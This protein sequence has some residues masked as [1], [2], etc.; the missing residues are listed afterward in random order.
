MTDQQHTVG[1]DL[2]KNS[3]YIVVVDKSCRVVEKKKRTRSQLVSYIAQR[4]ESTIAMEACASSHYWARTL[5]QLGHNVVLLPAQH[6]KGYSRGQKND[7]ND[8]Q[9]IAEAC[10]HGAIRPVLPKTVDEQDDST[11]ARIRQQLVHDRTRLA[12]HIRGILAE[13]GI[14]LPVGLHILKRSLPEILEDADNQLTY[15]MR[16]LLSRQRE[17]LMALDEEVDWYDEQLKQSVEKDS[18]CQR[19]LAIPGV[20]DIVAHALKQ[21][22]GNGQQFS[23]G[24]DASA[25]LGLV[26]RQHSTGGKARLM[27]ISKRGDARVRSA[28][29]HGARAVVS[30]ASKKDD[31][32]SRWI[33][34][35]VEHRGFNRAVVAYANKMVR[36]AW[37]CVAKK[38]RFLIR[39]AAAA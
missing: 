27:G 33:Q 2:A 34:R 25:A 10:H 28:V 31:P 29:I 17:R 14:V 6:V 32:L 35:L 8:A 22:M 19:M 15:R 5:T 36:F 4:P 11:F 13:Y 38:E 37:V 30:R 18:A 12:N 26:P 16:L 20:G 24:R 39:H 1:I 3:F 21:W 23:K 9:A 7:Y